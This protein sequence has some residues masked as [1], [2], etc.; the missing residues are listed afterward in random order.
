[1]YEVR[2]YKAQKSN[3]YIPR[4]YDQILRYEE[5]DEFATFF[6]ENFSKARNFVGFLPYVHEEYEVRP[7]TE[8]KPK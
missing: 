7:V 1:M 8:I 4:E 2:V 5:N 6:F 3:T